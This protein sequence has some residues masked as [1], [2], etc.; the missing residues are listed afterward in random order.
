MGGSV[1]SPEQEQLHIERKTRGNLLPSQASVLCT[2]VT[3]LLVFI[4]YL[5]KLITVTRSNLSIFI[6]T[7][8]EH[9]LISED[10]IDK[11]TSIQCQKCRGGKKKQE[12]KNLEQQLSTTTIAPGILHKCIRWRH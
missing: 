11:E 12:V 6:I 3:Y 4:C 7:A 2:L 8:S 1:T 5:E 10:G 9:S